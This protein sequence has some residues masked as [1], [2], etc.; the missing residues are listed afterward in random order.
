MAKESPVARRARE[1]RDRKSTRL[2][3]SHTVISYAV[4]S[5]NKKSTRLNSSHTVISYTPSSLKKKKPHVIETAQRLLNPVTPSTG[6]L[7]RHH[8]VTVHTVGNRWS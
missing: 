7:M 2:N 8:L 4:F 5:L 6:N 3:S 1:L